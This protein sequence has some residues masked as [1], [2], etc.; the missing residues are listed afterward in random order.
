LVVLLAAGFAGWKYFTTWRYEISTDDAYIRADIVAVAPQVSGYLSE[1]LVAEAQPVAAG[2]MLARIEPTPYANAVEQAEADLTAAQAS[3]RQAD[4]AIRLQPDLIAEARATVASSEA[5]NILAQENLARANALARSGTVSLQARQSA[6]AQASQAAAQLALA[7]AALNAAQRRTE[8]LNASLAEAQA[9][10]REAQ[11]SLATARF[12]LAQTNIVAPVAGVVGNRQMRQGLFVQ[13]GSQ[14]LSVVP[15][16][17]A[18][19]VANFK[20]TQVA[21]MQPGQAVSLSVD[22]YPD[23]PVRGVVE[24]IAPAAGQEFALLPPDN[25]TGNFT[26]I[27]QRVPVRVRIDPAF[28]QDQRLLPGMSVT[29]V[30]DV[31]NKPAS[32]AGKER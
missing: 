24:S 27:V 4:D 11:A 26:K 17:Q 6:T 19:V 13:P 20:E 5:A 32:E 22:A 18:Y 7:R 2:H 31:R 30:V 28:L 21:G 12:R 25:A 1:V 8:V 3:I 9:K 16:Q 14:L 29:A 10:A 15:L 23:L